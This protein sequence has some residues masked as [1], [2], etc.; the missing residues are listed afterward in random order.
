M[1]WLHLQDFFA[2]WG[3]EGVVNLIDVLS[4]LIILTASRTLL[5]DLLTLKI[6]KAGNYTVCFKTSC[7]RAF[8]WLG[9]SE[10]DKRF[11]IPLSGT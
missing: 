11:L 3:S 8:H 2:T 6:S 4:E 9:V 7:M 5:G 10:K 1:D